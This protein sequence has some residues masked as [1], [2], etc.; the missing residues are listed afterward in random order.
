MI[1]PSSGKY[2][3]LI[4]PIASLCI[5][6]LLCAFS[7]AQTYPELYVLYQ[8]NRITELASKVEQ[9]RSTK[10]QD[11][12]L[13]FFKALFNENGLEA[14]RI[15]EQTF[16]QSQGSLK[17]LA[18]E[19]LAQYYYARG[20]YVKAEEFQKYADQYI[21]VVIDKEKS[22][23]AENSSEK[24][25]AKNTDLYQIQVGAFS[26]RKN[27]QELMDHLAAKD[28][29]VQIVNREINGQTLYCVWVRGRENLDNTE[30]MA[31]EMKNKYKL[32]YRIIQP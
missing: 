7:F 29:Q 2:V 16:N 28:Y 31:K 15:Y 18:A 14:V 30:Q 19:K 3:S 11:S 9:L 25:E 21:P 32:S 22:K 6:I 24:I 8:T 27:A 1:F 5:V 23:S 26:V 12:E 13:L 17:N 4:Q 10:T 20:F